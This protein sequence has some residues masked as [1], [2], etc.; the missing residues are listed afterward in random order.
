MVNVPLPNGLERTE[1]LPRTRRLLQN[2][3]NNGTGQIISRP[4]ITEIN[5]TGTIARGQFVF[6]GFLYVVTGEVL[7]KITDSD[8]GD[9]IV[10]DTI[11]GTGIIASAI[12]FKEVVIL[13]KGGQMYTL[14][15][16]DEVDNIL[17][18]NA[19]LLANAPYVDVAYINGRF[20]YIPEDG[21]P[22]LFSDT[23][24]AVDVGAFNFFDAEELPDLNNAV[25][26]FKNTLYITGTD[27][28]QLF[29][30]SGPVD[31]PFRSIKRSRITNGFIGAL[32]EYNETFLFIGREKDQDFGIYA[33]AEGFAPKISNE[34]ID[35]ILGT[36]SQAE[37]A[38]AIG[39]RFKWRGHDI[40]YFT[41]A[42]DSFGYFGNNWF[43]METI[44][45]D[46][47]VPWG[48]GFINQFEGEYF[49]AFN[50]KIGKLEAIN[51]EYGQRITR[52]IETAFEDANNEWFA[53]QSI[54]LGISQGMNP[55]VFES[56]ENPTGGTPGSVGLSITRN[57]VTYGPQFFRELGA[58]GEFEKHLNW[59][60]PGGLGSYDGFMGIRIYTTQ[61]VIFNVNHLVANLR[62]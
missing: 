49:T 57:G 10:I 58:I 23:T 14:N 5:D 48:G 8:S 28:I 18:D 50:T 31:S 2:C 44:I 1:N 9:F 3:F 39:G 6:N 53:C 60:F 21:E 27:S 7:I 54:D 17:D 40:A 4:G 32:I 12:S 51:T 11:E 46:D 30:D 33:I 45:A 34:A 35:L 24:G 38:A 16:A 36:Y 26:N 56:M 62:G 47:S 55:V 19:I 29:T 41:L 25:F 59:N 61:D 22:A 42:R 43:V 15:E 20:V 13:V 52:I 37:L